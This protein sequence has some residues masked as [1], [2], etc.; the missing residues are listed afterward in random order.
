MDWEAAGAIGEVIGGIATILTLLY[1][2]YQIRNNT[3][4]TRGT[5][6]FSIQTAIADN[7]SAVRS[8]S[9]FAEIWLRGLKG[10]D[11]L[12]EVERARFTNHCLDLLNIATYVDELEKQNL[13]DTHID[14]IPWLT[15][16]YRDNPGFREFVDSL[17]DGFA[18]SDDLYRR[19]T[20][21][22]SAKGTNVY[23]RS[24]DA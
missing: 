15:V 11:A 5:T 20:D 9:E 21:L 19:L 6:S 2:A 24:A 4:A 8:D 16:I 13:G 18:G 23:D 14:F 1:L 3:K 7:L 22:E 17:R 12:S 10:L